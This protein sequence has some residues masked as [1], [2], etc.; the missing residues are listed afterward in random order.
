MHPMA[1]SASHSGGIGFVG[2]AL[3]LGLWLWWDG[4]AFAEWSLFVVAPG[5]GIGTKQTA[6]S[7][8][9]HA[10]LGDCRVAADVTREGDRQGSV[11][12]YVYFCGLACE[13]KTVHD[14]GSASRDAARCRR[15]EPG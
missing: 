8:S 2:L 15:L 4:R 7:H 6:I 13:T 12:R 5:T 9:Q 14:D 3:L 11:V 10:T 1:D